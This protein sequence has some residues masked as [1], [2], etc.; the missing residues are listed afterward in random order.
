MRPTARRLSPLFALALLTAACGSDGDTTAAP[1]EEEAR[2]AG[3]SEPAATESEA[4]G[5]DESPE[6]TSGGGGEATVLNATVGQPDDPDA[7]VITLTD[8]S[9]SPVETLPA[10]DYQ[11]VVSDLSSIHNFHLTG[12][13][14]VEETTSVAE[15]VDTTWDVTLE[16]GE[17]DYVCDPHPRMAGSFTVT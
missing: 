9:G 16:P 6:A 13:G 5:S 7:F 4:A 3:T 12:A 14:G 10:G 2:E 11:I 8:E 15:V 1:Q 17:Y